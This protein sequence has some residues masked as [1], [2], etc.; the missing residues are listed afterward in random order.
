[1]KEFVKKIIRE[2]IDKLLNEGR[3]DKFTGEVVA[4]VFKFIKI[5]RK[6]SKK[7]NEIKLLKFKRPKHPM[8]F[9]M[10][11]HIIREKGDFSV[12]VDGGAIVELQRPE[13][14]EPVSAGGKYM[15]LDINITSPTRNEEVQ[16]YKEIYYELNDTIRHEI[17]HLTQQQGINRIAG[18]VKPYIG[19]DYEE[20]IDKP[21][22]FTI[23]DEV[24]AM[25]AGM[26]RKA[27][28]KRLP[29]DKIY[30]A[31][32]NNFIER[33]FI[34]QAEKEKIMNIWIEYTKKN[35]PTAKFSTLPN[36]EV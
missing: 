30:D 29:I 10:L 22:Y 36:A 21:D 17:E 14:D 27:K 3:F 9:Y 26:Y 19:S 8:T 15:E 12:R 35:Y 32:L 16:M 34:T 28:L 7:K 11:V 23:I 5:T 18:R 20:I 2:E 31:Y 13:D 33:K 25:V 6:Y 24:P 1:M 4:E